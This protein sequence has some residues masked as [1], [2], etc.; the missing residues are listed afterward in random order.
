MAVSRSNK[1]NATKQKSKYKVDF[2]S[3]YFA[4]ILNFMEKIRES[5]KT[6]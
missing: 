3:K 5:I 2:Y 1:L 4:N 6:L